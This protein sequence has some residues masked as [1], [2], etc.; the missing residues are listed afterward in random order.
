L[1]PEKTKEIIRKVKS[2]PLSSYEKISNE[3]DRLVYEIYELTNE[4]ILVIEN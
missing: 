3:I 4:E 2:K 1:Q